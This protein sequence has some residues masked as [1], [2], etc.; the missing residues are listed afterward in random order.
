MDMNGAGELAASLL[1]QLG[2]GGRDCRL[3]W[4]V[5]VLVADGR[6]AEAWARDAAEGVR[7]R[8]GGMPAN[9][10]GYFRAALR[11]IMSRNA[12]D[13]ATLEATV[14][15]P[16]RL[17]TIQSGQPSRVRAGPGPMADAFRQSVRERVGGAA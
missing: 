3:V 7:R 13:L 15:L 4:K 16:K 9:P 11:E 2:Y 5:A 10:I 1:R 17:P 14:K 6:I 8:S 12:K